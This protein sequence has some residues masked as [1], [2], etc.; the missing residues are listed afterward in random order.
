MSE[1]IGDFDSAP[2]VGKRKC[3]QHLKQDFNREKYRE[4][5]RMSWLR[6][7]RIRKASAVFR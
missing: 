4:Y 3:T 1:L 5:K 7:K 6:P 2:V